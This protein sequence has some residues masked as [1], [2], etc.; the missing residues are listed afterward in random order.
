MTFNRRMSRLPMRTLAVCLAAMY[1]SASVRSFIP[2]MCATQSALLESVSPGMSSADCCIY[3]A[4]RTSNTDPAKGLK[5]P[6]TG[7]C[8]LCYLALSPNLTPA[9]APNLGEAPRAAGFSP[10]ALSEHEPA[11]HAISANPGRAPPA[12]YLS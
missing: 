6:K 12:I 1:V 3:P 10:L 7:K 5:F 9:Y 8:A 11:R 2:G 4:Q